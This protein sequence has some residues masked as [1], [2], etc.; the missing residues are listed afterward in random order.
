[1]YHHSPASLHFTCI[2]V[3]EVDRQPQPKPPRQST[4]Q[5][6]PILTLPTAPQAD[7]PEA[8]GNRPVGLSNSNGFDRRP[9]VWALSRRVF[10]G[11]FCLRRHHR[12]CRYGRSRSLIAF[13]AF[14]LCF[15][16]LRGTCILVLRRYSTDHSLDRECV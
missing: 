13:F 3:L 5:K 15:W 14:L 12:P 11:Y 10:L 2:E 6:P 8:R 1:V 7:R 16:V 4:P 9:R